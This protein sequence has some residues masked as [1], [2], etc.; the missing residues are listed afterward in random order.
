MSIGFRAA[1]NASSAG[2][3]ASQAITIPSTVQAG[4]VLFLVFNAYSGASGS[5]TLTVTSTG[6]AWTQLGTTQFESAASAETNSAIFYLQAGSSDA[7]ATVTC[8][9]SVSLFVNATI[10]AYSGANSWKF[11]DVTN[12][13]GS[14]TLTSTMAVS[15]VAPAGTADWIIYGLSCCNGA[16]GYSSCTAPAGTTMREA[17]FGSASGIAAIADSNGAV[18]PG[19]SNGGGHFTPD[20]TGTYTTWTIGL[21]A[22]YVPPAGTPAKARF[23]LPARGR[24]Y[25]LNPPRTL[26][27]V[28]SSEG[29]ASGTTATRANSGGLSGSAFDAVAI[30]AGGTMAFNST[31]TAHGLRSYKVAVGGTAGTSVLEWTTSLGGPQPVIYYRAYLYY[32]AFP[33]VASSP[34]STRTGASVSSASISVSSTGKINIRDAAFTTRAIVAQPIPLNQWFRVEGYFVGNAVNGAASASLYYPMDSVTAASTATATG[35]N[36][37]GPANAVWFGESNSGTN[38]GPWWIDD[39]GISNAGYLGPAGPPSGAVFY[40]PSQAVRARLPQQPLLR[41]RVTSSP[42]SVP[43]VAVSGSAK[44]LQ[45]NA[46]DKLAYLYDGSLI[47][48]YWSGT[49][50]QVG[51]VTSPL[52]GL[53]VTNLIST[54]EDGISIWVD[55][56]AGTSSDIW[57]CSSDDDAS[58]G[59]G[60]SLHVRHGTYT[61][62]VFTWD[63]STLISG[64]T[65]AAT[66]QSTITW[67]GT[68]LM[69]FWW[70]GASGS[71]RVSYAYTSTKNGTSGWT[72]A[73]T[74]SESATWSTIVQVCARHS[75]K[76]GAT[77]VVYGGNSQMHYAC[78]AD[79]A[80]SP[81]TGN[82]GGR[83]VYDQFDD[84]LELFGGPQVVIDES[85]GAIHVAR[86]VANL[87]GPS[88]DGVIYWHGTYTPGASGSVSF[89]ARVTVASAA[90]A[91]GPA[92]IAAAVDATGTVWV[93]WT[94]NAAQGNLKYATLTAPF[95][96]ASAATTLIAG[97]ATSN[98]RWPHVP[99]VSAAQAGLATFLPVLYMDTTGS[100]FP[101]LLNTSIAL[102]ATPGPVFWPAS[103]AVRARLP[104]PPIGTG[105]FRGRVSSN[106]G[107]PVRSVPT[108]G[109]VFTQRPAPVR[110][111]LPAWQPR[112]G[113]IGSS[114]GAPVINPVHGPPV[115]PLQGEVRAQLPPLQPRAGR[116]ASCPGSPPRNPSAGPVFYPAVRP[117]RAPVPPVFSK[118]RVRSGPGSAA[119]NPSAGPGVYAPAGPVRIRTAPPFSKGRVTSGPGSPARNPSAGPAVY[120]AQGPVRARTVPPF[121]KGRT[122]SNPG[123]PVTALPVPGPVFRQAPAPARIRPALPLRGRISSNPGGPVQNPLPPI[124][125]PVFRPFRFP[126]RARII[127]PPRGRVT[128]SPGSP[129]RN[130]SAGPVFV[131]APRPARAP[132]PQVFSKGRVSSGPG[133]APRNPSPGPVFRQAVRPARAPVPQVFSKGRV[134]SCAGAPARN[135]VSGPVIYAQHGPARARTAPPF[136]KGRAG[137]NAGAPARNPGTGHVFIQA[138]RPAQARLPLPA[139][140]RI[141]S[142]AGGPVRNPVPPIFGPPFYPARSPA[143]IRVTLPPRGRIASGSG[144]PARNPGTGPAVYAAHGPVRARVPQVFSKGRVR[145]GQG[146]HVPQEAPVYPQHGP[147][148]AHPVPPARG[149]IASGPGIPVPATVPVPAFA[150]HGPVRARITLPA[151]GRVSIFRAPAIQPVP[152]PVY[153]QHGPVAARQP[154]SRRGQVRSGAGTPVR[155]PAP[156][157]PLRRPVQARIPLPAR[158]R[159]AGN[160]GAPVRNPGTGPK[161]YPQHGPAGLAWRAPGPFRK[162]SAQGSP[163]RFTATPAMSPPFAAGPARWAWEAGSARPVWAGGPARKTWNPG[164]GRNQ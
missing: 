22:T 123:G 112:A 101:V 1:A 67:N 53:S 134:A 99:A 84:S 151:R 61:G 58:G 21:A 164:S 30:A 111:A 73:A 108:Q 162:G 95:T 88:W 57:V 98:P 145:S 59:A 147:V 10:S 116:S 161:V 41:G 12:T 90:S 104:Q 160:P 91:T 31:R 135:P 139:R 149:R 155:H 27:I 62:G 109:P 128:S 93:L 103:Q 18:A 71:D 163:G 46:A 6:S 141:S 114:F 24:T 34:V 25:P 32:T 100:P 17:N 50:G 82:W 79:S 74:F 72:A 63:A 92:D 13:T 138:V 80:A 78:L 9:T 20:Q 49:Q 37:A 2:A 142:N 97:S 126:A 125:G 132:V 47:F 144:A 148:R 43:P 86:A 55:N 48:G 124:F 38:E 14:A 110:Y 4:D 64:T 130:P 118:G 83:T 77:V 68:Y 129:P 66:I 51:H 15:S 39:I 16:T 156:A 119:R 140:G 23:P 122:G 153:P 136:S 117:V 127:P 52:A 102:P 76:L 157:Y 87:G 115:Y 35:M 89:A 7:S 54:A 106:P 150:Q 159:T 69:V 33:A 36:N 65:T 75:Y 45:R 5:S 19:S 120:A 113:R 137:S 26:R 96:S 42:G 28:N 29:G 146:T 152:A 94:D 105:A 40:P 60:P 133:T 3:V 11:L 56:S 143:R 107:T 158:G 70:D 121:S 81:A 154:L 44:A 8:H 85:S 131:Q